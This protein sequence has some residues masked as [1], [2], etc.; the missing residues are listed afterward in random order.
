MEKLEQAISDI[1]D[2]LLGYDRQPDGT[3]A[4]EIDADYRDEPLKSY[5]PFMFPSTMY[6]TLVH[7]AATLTSWVT[8]MIVVPSEFNFTSSSI[9]SSEEV[10]FKAP[11]GSSAKII[12][13]LFIILRQIHAR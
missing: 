9:T 4:Y 11:V 3:F 10:R 8:S 5:S 1:L 6:M 7:F 12:F 2:T 13:G